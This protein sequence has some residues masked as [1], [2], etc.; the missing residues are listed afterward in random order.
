MNDTCTGTQRDMLWSIAAVSLYVGN[1]APHRDQ[2]YFSLQE[3][4]TGGGTTTIA[5]QPVLASEFQLPPSFPTII[6]K[7]NWNEYE[8]ALREANEIGKGFDE[9]IIIL[10]TDGTFSGGNEEE[11]RLKT[12]YEISRLLPKTGRAKLFLVICNHNGLSD[13]DRKWWEERANR[14]YDLKEKVEWLPSLVEEQIGWS[15]SNQN[16]GGWFTHTREIALPPIPGDAEKVEINMVV[17]S[18]VVPFQGQPQYRLAPNGGDYNFMKQTS[19]NIYSTGGIPLSP[20]GNCDHHSNTIILPSENTGLY[21]IEIER[22]R[23]SMII[24]P[25]I[26]VNN[27]PVTIQVQLLDIPSPAWSSCYRTDFKIEGGIVEQQEEIDMSSLSANYVWRPSDANYP[28]TITG[29]FVLKTTKGEV[30]KSIDFGVE[31]KFRPRITKVRSFPCDSGSSWY[32]T[33]F[34]YEFPVQYLPNSFPRV[35]LCTP[36]NP[37]EIRRVNNDEDAQRAR[38]KDRSHDDLTCP[39]PDDRIFSSYCYR[40]PADAECLSAQRPAVIYQQESKFA[41]KMYRFL[42]LP[43]QCEYRTVIFK[44][45]E[46]SDTIPTTWRCS[47]YDGSCEED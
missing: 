43:E 26:S 46:A 6:E 14:I 40:V 13:S 15:L 2:L 10:F 9:H 36:K 17:I 31:V 28:R 38:G 41:L 44:W 11:E 18:P 12:A 34:I 33:Q 19:L 35:F 3:F 21:T 24:T 29:T 30:I 8:K 47:L 32:Q 27:E 42:F 20:I 39:V 45:P 25:G 5:L 4:P 37:N 22:P 16:I 7:A 23:P 1:K